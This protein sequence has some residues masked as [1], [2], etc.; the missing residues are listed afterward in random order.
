MVGVP[1]PS[2]LYHHDTKGYDTTATE[3]EEIS[4]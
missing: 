1:E 4:F 3:L 2:E